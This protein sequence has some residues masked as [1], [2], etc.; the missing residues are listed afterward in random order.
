MAILFKNTVLCFYKA[1]CNDLQ[2]TPVTVVKMFMNIF[3]KIIA[4]Q[5]YVV[6]KIAILFLKMTLKQ[7]QKG[8]RSTSTNRKAIRYTSSEVRQSSIPV[9]T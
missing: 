3:N 1:F 9:L 7:G 6:L 8:F 4:T 5:F 2:I